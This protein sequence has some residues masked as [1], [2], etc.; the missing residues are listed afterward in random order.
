MITAQVTNIPEISNHG[1]QIVPFWELLVAEGG[2]SGASDTVD[3]GVFPQ[4]GSN[5]YSDRK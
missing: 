3:K 4:L 2:R 1:P 5:N